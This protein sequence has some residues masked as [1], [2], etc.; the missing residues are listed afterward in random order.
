MIGFPA[1]DLGYFYR[2]ALDKAGK[3]Y[4]WLVRDKE[5]HGFYSEENNLAFYEALQAFLDK[6]IGKDAH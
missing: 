4:E 3:P 2:S 6:H 5:Q 1:I